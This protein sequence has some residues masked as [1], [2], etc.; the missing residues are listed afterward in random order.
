MDIIDSDSKIL[1]SNS[2]IWEIKTPQAE[3]CR[4]FCK[5]LNISKRL[6]TILINRGIND[7]DQ[8][9]SFLEP[10]LHN[11]PDP[12]LMAGMEMAVERLTLAFRRKE[13]IAVFGD[14]DMDGISATAIL[15]DYLRRAGFTQVEFSIPSRLS[16]GYGLNKQALTYAG[17]SGVTLAL[18]VDNGISNLEEV[19]AAKDLGIDVI[20]TDHHQIPEELP[21]AFAIINPHLLE[22][23]YPDKN[24]AGVGVA[25]NLMMALRKRLRES[26]LAADVNLLQYLDLVALG[27]VADV[28]PL[29]GVNRIFVSFGLKEINKTSR[30]GMLYLLSAAGIKRDEPISARDLAFKLAPRVNAVGRVADAKIA[31]ELF[32][33]RDKAIAIRNV[34]TLE[35]C[36]ERRRQ[37]EKDIKSEVDSI[38]KDDTSLAA[39]KVIL[40][41]SENW[42]P[43]VVG[44]VS[45]RVTEAYDKPAILIAIENGVGRGSG[46]SV[47]GLNL[48]AV[49][50]QCQEH[51]IRYGGH[52]QA[53][54]LTVAEESI[55]NLREEI[56]NYFTETAPVQIEA[57]RISLD[58][59]LRPDEINRKLLDEL[60]VL[61]PLGYGNPEPMFLL[62]A[63]EIA[64]ITSMDSNGRR[65]LKFTFTDSRDRSK[66]FAGI[67]FNFKGMPP[68]NGETL[69]LVCTPEENIWRGRSEIRANLTDLRI[70]NGENS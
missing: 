54:G 4:K 51:L 2:R 68:K 16:D 11:L 66:R 43:G 5:E 64:K 20:V 14:Y 57:P 45:S 31:V 32:L 26:G 56:E 36:N 22:C 3:L 50:D 37:I 63:T 67:Y 7:L 69:D 70:S 1:R 60:Q 35:E 24:L 6:A 34:Q 55:V 12:Y 29:T 40:L 28:M 13:K 21:P 44:I 59:T 52:E 23:N 53:V 30:L 62:E 18:T 49:L 46:R 10:S 47:P 38:L 25:F 58:G 42:H 8:A 39:A 9:V 17:K 15:V 33:T 65:H 41:A 19:V 48:V 27:T 61:H